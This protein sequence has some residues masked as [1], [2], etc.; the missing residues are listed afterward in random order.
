MTPQEFKK[1]YDDLKS[2]LLLD[3]DI[4][5]F[6]NITSLVSDF[7]KAKTA[8]ELVD[9]ESALTEAAFTFGGILGRLI[10]QHEFEKNEVERLKAT[11]ITR[12]IKSG[13]TK[14]VTHAEQMATSALGDRLDLLDISAGI[15]DEYKNKMMSLKDIFLAITHRIKKLEANA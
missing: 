1:K 5:L 6:K 13:E 9:I 14:R 7:P 12:L 3:S 15:V 2:S 11:E 8:S 4:E 10:A